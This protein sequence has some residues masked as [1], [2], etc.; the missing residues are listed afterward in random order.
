M[1]IRHLGRMSHTS[2]AEDS[3]LKSLGRPLPSVSPSATTPPGSSRGP[4]GKPHPHT[5]ARELSKTD[6]TVTLVNDFKLAAEAAKRCGFDFVEIHGAH[7]YLFDQFFN[8]HTNLRTDEFGCQSIE[9]RT[10]A[11]SLVLETVIG[12]FKSPK[13]VG[14]R[15]SPVTKETFS[16]QGA[17][18]NDPENTYKGVI[19][20]LNKYNLGYLLITE[21]RWNGGIFDK[22]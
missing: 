11:L 1:V 8:D 9:N 5:A 14:I 22:I 17:K 21:P 2:W 15:I 13:R 3:F 20:H 18:D 6:I 7:G 12:V 16:F 19:E 4:D 10:R